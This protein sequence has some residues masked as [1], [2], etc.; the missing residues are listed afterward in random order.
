MYLDRDEI[1]LR[2]EDEN[3]LLA[4][5]RLTIFRPGNRIYPQKRW[6]IQWEVVKARIIDMPWN[7]REK[8]APTFSTIVKLVK[9]QT[10]KVLRQE[11]LIENDFRDSLEYVQ[12]SEDVKKYL[13]NIYKEI[14]ET[15]TKIDINELDT[16]N[17]VDNTNEIKE[18]F[19]SW[20]IKFA[21]LPENNVKNIEEL[22]QAK[23]FSIAFINHDYA[24]ITPKMWNHIANKYNLGIKTAFVVAD[25]KD[26]ESILNILQKSNK[27]IWWWLGV[28]F[29]DTWRK[30]VKEKEYWFIN[31]I[32]DEMQSI[33]FIAHFGEEIHWSNSD[34]SWYADSLCDK[35]KE[36]GEDIVGKDI[37]I[38]WAGGTARWIA[39]ELMNRWAHNI[40]VLNRTIEK[41]EHI[42]AKLNHIKPN[43]AIAGDENMIFS[44]QDKKIDAIINLSTKWADGD[45]ASYS[46]LVST[47]WWIQENLN[48]TKEVLKN[49]KRHNPNIIISDINLTKTQTTPLLE[50]AKEEWLSILDG[51]LMVIYQGVQAI[52][53]VF[54]DKI[55]QAGG[56]KQ[57]VQEELLKIIH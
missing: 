18:L 14:P 25:P 38:L 24:G 40:T 32:A 33:N 2:Q 13:E 39:L 47:Q 41:A 6:F 30:I 11:D 28:W 34:A 45:C 56:T 37:I 52:W 35:F 53:T 10:I 49:L 26:F 4:K 9:I 42:T 55:I 29:K 5:E 1:G 19:T 22:L 43:I 50:L 20:R 15:I 8:I 57:E 7:D 54:G 21:E 27:Y 23:N 16:E 3:D 36:I 12:S 44:L 48:K 31:P 17:L 46:W 51:K